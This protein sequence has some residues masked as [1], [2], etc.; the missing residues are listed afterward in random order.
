MVW[1]KF[2]V[3]PHGSGSSEH[4]SC[5]ITPFTQLL[6]CKY[7]NSRYGAVRATPLHGRWSLNAVLIGFVNIT[8]CPELLFCQ[9]SNSQNFLPGTGCCS[10]AALSPSAGAE[11]ELQTCQ[12]GPVQTTS[13]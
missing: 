9:T 11:A 7:L 4:N 1:F 2:S 3:K 6:L 5:V 12:L 10:F 13:V 8:C